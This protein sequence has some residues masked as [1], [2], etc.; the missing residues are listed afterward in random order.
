MVRIKLK[1]KIIVVIQQSILVRLIN[2]THPKIMLI[3]SNN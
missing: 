3:H 2:R 1:I